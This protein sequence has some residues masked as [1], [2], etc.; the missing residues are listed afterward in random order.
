MKVFQAVIL[1]Q[2]WNPKEGTR[3]NPVITLGRL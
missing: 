1:G 3:E 2:V